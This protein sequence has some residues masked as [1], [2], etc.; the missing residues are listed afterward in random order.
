MGAEF[1]FSIRMRPMRFLFARDPEIM[2][3]VLGPVYRALST[4]LISKA[5]F[6]R[7][8]A[9]TGAVTLIQHFGS[10]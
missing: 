3:Q 1:S 8:D 7:R 5:G 9:Q 10:A 6:T 2:G 4:Y